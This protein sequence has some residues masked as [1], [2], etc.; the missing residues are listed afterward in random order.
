MSTSGE[1]LVL[2]PGTLCDARVFAPVLARL[3]GVAA[4]VSALDGAETTPAMAERLLAALPR[5]FALAGFSL[6]GIVALEI[7]AQ[8]PD[9]VTRL[10][11]L[12][13]TARPDSPER[14]AARRE[15]VARAGELGVAGYVADSLWPVYVADAGRADATARALVLAMADALGL[16][17]FR[18]HAELAINRADS[19]PRLPAITVPTLVL[20]GADDVLCPPDVH[21]EIAAAVPGARLVVVPEAGHFALI[22]RPDAVAGALADWL[23]APTPERTP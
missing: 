14:H 12:D 3:P 7:V 21:R 9:R 10:A 13:T 15:A 16:D 17:A 20:C 8:Q 19:R 23:A 18:T 6:G 22:E 4:Q 5:R 1:P 2:L 11:L